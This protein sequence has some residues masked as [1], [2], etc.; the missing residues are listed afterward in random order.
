[1]TSQTSIIRFT[2]RTTSAGSVTLHQEEID[3]SDP[4][5]TPSEVGMSD[6]HTLLKLFYTRYIGEGLWSL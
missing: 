6:H 4:N 5:T 1:M 2:I 3:G